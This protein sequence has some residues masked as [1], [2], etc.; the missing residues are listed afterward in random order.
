MNFHVLSCLVNIISEKNEIFDEEKFFPI[1]VNEDLCLTCTKCIS[2][3]PSK[4]IFFKGTGRFVHYNR[5]KG[6]LRCV[7]V[8]KY[9]AIEVISLKEGNLIGFEIL[10]EKCNLCGKCI[11]PDFCFQNLFE[12]VPDEENKL[13]IQFK[14]GNFSLCNGCLKCFKDCPNNAILPIIT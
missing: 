14:T 7:Y 6:C 3:C 5:C 13:I 9:G 11:E 4:A 8:C 10:N 1:S 2:R 12:K